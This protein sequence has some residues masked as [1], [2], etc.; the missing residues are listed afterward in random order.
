MNNLSIGSAFRRRREYLNL[1]QK[2]VADKIDI[3]RQSD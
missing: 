3:S 2:E 1:T